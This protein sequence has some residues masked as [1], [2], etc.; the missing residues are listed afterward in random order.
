L[1]HRRH[2]DRWCSEGGRIQFTATT[3]TCRGPDHAF[4]RGGRRRAPAGRWNSG[5]PVPS[6][7]LAGRHAHPDQRHPAPEPATTIANTTPERSGRA[8]RSRSRLCRRE[9]GR[10]ARSTNAA[11]YPSLPISGSAEPASH[12]ASA[13]PH[14]LHRLGKSGLASHRTPATNPGGRRMSSPSRS[15][16]DTSDSPAFGATTNPNRRGCRIRSRSESDSP[17]PI[18]PSVRPTSVHVTWSRAGLCR[19]R[20][21]VHY[22]P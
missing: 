16:Q 12:T 8:T 4:P 6:A 9:R 20:P 10:E 7:S 3:K 11:Q 21:S 19:P 5:D 14:C 13:L 18:P 1:H 2:S 17:A 22:S 15:I